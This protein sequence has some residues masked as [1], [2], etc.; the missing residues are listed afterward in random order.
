MR[1]LR[2][3]VVAI[4]GAASGIGRA[5][6]L[7]FAVGGA[8]VALLDIDADGLEAVA[9]EV[10]ARGCEVEVLRCDVCDPISCEAAVAAVEERWGGVDVLINNAGITH[11]SKFVDTELEVIR[12]VMEVNFFGTVHCTR[13]ALTSLIAR[14]GTIVALSS[15]A[16]F[17]PLFGRCGYAASKHAL[18]GFLDTLR[19]ELRADGVEVMLVCPSYVATPLSDNALG[20]N[21]A[22]DGSDGDRLPQ[23]P[24]GKQQ[25][26]EQ[27]ADAIFGGVARARRRLLPSA[28]SKASYWLWTL[29]PSAYERVML[30]SQRR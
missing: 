25:T 8:R 14:R 18:H 4:T 23:S 30:A 29:M 22:P 26:P 28:L 11:R 5:L 24:V 27:V 6:T 1:E 19:S 15:V 16:G 9:A 12:R 10:R 7:R 3:K 20:G 13:A 17:A 2:G 21:A